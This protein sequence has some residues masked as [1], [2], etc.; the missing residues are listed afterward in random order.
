LKEVTAPPPTPYCFCKSA[1]AQERK[2]VA[3]I[4]AHG[5]S[6][7]SAEKHEKKQDE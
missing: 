2:G 4:S 5:K 7:K 1:E 3:A 6:E